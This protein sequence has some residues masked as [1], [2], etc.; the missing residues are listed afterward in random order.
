MKNLVPYLLIAF[1]IVVGGGSIVLLVHFPGIGPAYP[2][3]SSTERLTL[4]A[5]LCLIFFVQ[6]SGMIRRR[7]KEW[8]GAVIPAHYYPAVYAI[9][10]GVA[11][12]AMVIF[13]QRTDEVLY[14]L[15]GPAAWMLT[16]LS[17]LGAAGFFWGA[18]SL[19]SGG[20]DPLGLS[21]IRKRLRG[22]DSPAS[23]LAIR[24]PYR[25]VRHPLYFF[26]LLV[27]WST[28]QATADVLLS[29]LLFT[30]WIVVSTRWEERDLVAQFGD[31]YRKYQTA[32]PMLLPFSFRKTV[33]WLVGR[34]EAEITDKSENFR[35][36]TAH[37]P[38]SM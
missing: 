1:A 27:I 5:L 4:D 20:F 7:F 9:A 38:D 31:D 32:V 34:P 35:S 18:W 21:P 36:A 14:S 8:A 28:P 30:C 11:L 3:L 6:H 10:S 19:G 29:N 33:S 16:G 22:A 12:G 15:K 13:W 24:G 37:F 26:V 2:S 25:F 17:A 23:G